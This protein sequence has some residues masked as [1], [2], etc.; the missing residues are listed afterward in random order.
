MFTMANWAANGLAK[1]ATP[2]LTD[3]RAATQAVVTA[4]SRPDSAIYVP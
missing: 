1:P 4:L 3:L 2:E